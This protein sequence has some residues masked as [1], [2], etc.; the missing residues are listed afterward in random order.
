MTQEREYSPEAFGRAGSSVPT[1]SSR[2]LRMIY[3]GAAAVWGFTAGVGG[4][5]VGLAVDGA[6][7]P[8]GWAATLALVPAAVVALGGA[9]IIAGAY[10]EAK[11]R[12]R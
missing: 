4:F 6:S 10:Q 3:F 9:G 8:A 11:R 5:L 7:A 2:R 1:T 12:R